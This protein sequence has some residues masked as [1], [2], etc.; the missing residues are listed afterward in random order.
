MRE[1]LALRP[2]PFLFAFALACGTESSARPAPQSGER[3]VAPRPGALKSSD[4]ARE[5]KRP[6]ALHPPFPGPGASALL[7]P[8][9][10]LPDAVPLSVEHVGFGGHWLVACSA[11]TDTDKNGRLAVDVGPGGNLVGDALGVELVVGAEK[12]ELIDDLLAYDPTGRYVAVRRAARAWLVDAGGGNDLDLT[13]LDWDDRDDVL[14]RRNHRALAFDPRGELVAYVRR[15]ANRPEVVVRSLTSGVEHAVTDVPGEPYRMAWDGTGEQLVVTAVAD[16]TNGNG[17]LDWPAPAAK[18]RRFAC[19][20]PLP[21][22]RVTPEVGDRPSTFIAPRSGG[23]ARFVP[24]LAVPFGAT[25]VVRAPDGE[26]LLVSG[27]AR[28]ALTPAS[29]GARILFA[30]PARGL[31][32][33]GCPGKNPQKAAVELVG[34][35]YRLELG[36][37]V[38]PTSLDAWPGTPTRLV[39]LYPGLDAL[40]VDLER[41]A[42]VRLE[43]GDQVLTTNGPRALVRRR[44]SIVLV[45]VD[46]NSTKTLAPRLSRLPFVLVQGTAVAVGNTVFDVLRDE[47]LGTV[48]GRPLALA[49][50]GEALVARGGPP[51]AER[52]ALGPLAWEKPAERGGESA[53]LGARML[54]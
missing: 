4:Q 52:L 10:A 7:L 11:R 25:V 34:A 14:P 16:D 47:P 41:R 39:A 13:A 28:K 3:R 42:V 33:V 12:P 51:S 30:D 17:R 24:D 49:P 48:S 31:L 53:A 1:P 2:S 45:D 8:R 29:C 38:Q 6:S 20:G 26:L 19:S 23:P 27:A 36:V 32:L 50:S 18:G 54:R 21:R 15:R 44:G 9:A 35:G 43:P 40:L 22:F 46:K 5:A 37:E